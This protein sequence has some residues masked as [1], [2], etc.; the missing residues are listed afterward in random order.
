MTLAHELGHW[1]SGDAYDVE[2]SIDSERMI[3]S[4]A[5]HFLA[6]RAGLTKVWNEHTDWSPRDRALAVGASFRLSWSAALGQLKNVGIIDQSRYWQLT[7]D[8]PR[9]GDYL[10]LG[11]RWEDELSGPYLSPGFASAS[12][13]G[14]VSGRLTAARTLEL[15]RGT[16]EIDDLPRQHTL[17]LE[18]LRRSFAGHD[19]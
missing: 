10:R 18:D 11:L 9:H 6:P 16:L 14:Y 8:E 17:S 5:I 12:V 19:G 3:Y 4:F 2:A 15:L 13:N 7:D 1:L